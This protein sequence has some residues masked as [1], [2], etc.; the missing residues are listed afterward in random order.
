[1]S[2]EVPSME[3]FEIHKFDSYRENNR[4]EVKSAQGGL[5]LS[6]WETY[7][8]FANTYGGIIILGAKENLDGSLKTSGLKNI[9][10]LKK[11]FWAT[12]NNK[13]KVSINLL[14]E[15][16]L[17][18]YEYNGDIILVIHV[19]MAKREQR[20]VYINNDIFNGTYKRNNDGDFHC[21]KLQ[22]Q[23]MLRDQIDDS[24]SKTIE[25]FD[26]SVFDKESVSG[27]R[28]RHRS[29]R[30]A[31]P[32][33]S[34]E[35]NAYLEMIG[36]A[37]LGKDMNYHPTAAGL[38][39]F[40]NEYKIAYEFP[41]YFLDYKEI[42]ENI[43]WT[44][45]L[46]SQS[47]DWSGNL[48]DFYFRVY[49]KLTQN[50]KV[51]FKTING[52]RI[53]DTPVHEVLREALANTLANSDFYIPR[54]I[55]ITQTLDSIVFENPGNIR[56]GKT[57]MLKGGISDPRNK[58]IMKMFNLIG[59]GERAGSGIPK[60]WKVWNEEGYESPFIEELYSDVERTRLTLPLTKKENI[61]ANPFGTSGTDR[62]TNSGTNKNIGDIDKIIENANKFGTSGTNHGTNSGTSGGTDELCV[63]IISLIQK[64]N[65]ISITSMTEQLKI[66]KRT[67]YR[68]LKTLKEKGILER[69][70]TTRSGYWIVHS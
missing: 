56:V 23:A 2:R 29:Y 48:F 4:L 25:Y 5:P 28:N 20:P 67:L 8:S 27:Y 7:S 33:T 16:D 53:D 62:G 47:G 18:V 46:Q 26:L 21:S 42:F 32:W 49:G 31:H 64:N 54:G 63:Q 15:N 17:S 39:M 19:P 70:G 37:K 66:S 38:L 34:L 41:E 51:P 9:I 60:L 30:S 36:A 6:L 13:G 14:S 35:D 43:R 3:I 58:T 40:G 22:V 57:Q 69:K 61:G 52:T 44:D 24:D 45:R 12:L 1:M 59:I 65:R 50:V 10:S 55:T 68:I 11:D